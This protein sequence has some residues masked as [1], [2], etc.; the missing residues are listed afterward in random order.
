MSYSDREDLLKYVTE[1]Y[2]LR[3]IGKILNKSASTLSRELKMNC[4][5]IKHSNFS[6]DRRC[7]HYKNCMIRSRSCVLTCPNFEKEI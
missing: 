2:S 4:F 1:G 6:Q 5:C 3:R 7:A